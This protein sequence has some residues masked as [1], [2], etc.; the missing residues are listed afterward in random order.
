MSY[1]R[2]STFLWRMMKSILK[3]SFFL[4]TKTNTGCYDV[5]CKGARYDFICHNG[6]REKNFFAGYGHFHG[7]KTY[8]QYIH[9]KY[10]IRKVIIFKIKET[11]NAIMLLTI[12]ESSKGYFMMSVTHR[13]WKGRRHLD[14]GRW[15]QLKIKWCS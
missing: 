12:T 6:I 10:I 5:F 14:S 13:I 9:S 2:M 3:E 1:D 7:E 11:N 15:C 8:D 4:S